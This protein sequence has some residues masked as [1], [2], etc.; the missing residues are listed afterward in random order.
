MCKLL[1]IMAHPRTAN[2]NA[3]AWNSKI[4]SL[5]IN[6]RGKSSKIQPLLTQKAMVPTKVKEVGIGVP[7]KYFDLPVTSFGNLDTVTLNLANRVNP[8][9]TKNTKSKQS[10]VVLNPMQKATMAGATPKDTKSAKESNSC[11][12]NEDLLRIRATRPSKKSKN[13]PN[14]IKTCARWM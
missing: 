2:N 12:I 4:P 8:H 10:T 13:N 9:K 3:T 7:S 11:P 5:K 6:P 14:A 1:L